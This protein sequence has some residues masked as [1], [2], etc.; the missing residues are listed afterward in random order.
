MASLRKRYQTTES[1][2]APVMSPPEVTAAELPPAVEPK[3]IE[4]PETESAADKA[5]K[6][7]LQDRLKEMERAEGLQR[8]Q[9]QPQPAAAPPPQ[10]QQPAMP[11]AVAKWLAAHPQYTDPND[12]I[13]QVEISLATMKAA[14]D[15][16]TWNDDDFLPSIER[17]LGIAPRTNGHVESRPTP[18][19]ANS[20]R[21]APNLA[22]PRQQPAPRMSA[23]VSAPP[24]REPPSMSTGRAPLYRAPLN[25]DELEIAATSGMTPEEYQKKKEI[26]QRMKAEGHQ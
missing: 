18:Q 16:L 6:T 25:R 9:Q 15:G 4:Q 23:A 20:A 22:P 24:S 13:A 11:A 14:R 17:H 5:A 10:E 2:D 21:G 7:A 1:K 12:Q 19:P 26:W 8:Q 3:P